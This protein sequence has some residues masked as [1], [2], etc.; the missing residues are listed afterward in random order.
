ML[1]SPPHNVAC[2]TWGTWPRRATIRTPAQEEEMVLQSPVPF[3]APNQ[4]LVSI[5]RCHTELAYQF[6]IHPK[7]TTTEEGDC[8]KSLAGSSRARTKGGV[9]WPFPSLAWVAGEIGVSSFF[10][11]FPPQPRFFIQYQIDFEYHPPQGIHYSLSLTRPIP[12][13]GIIPPRRSALRIR[14]RGAHSLPSVTPSTH[15]STLC[16]FPFHWGPFTYEGGHRFVLRIERRTNWSDRCRNPVQCALSLPEI[17]LLS[18]GIFCIIG[19]GVIAII[20]TYLLGCGL[21]SFAAARGS[22]PRIRI[23]RYLVSSFW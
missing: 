14:M 4:T 21:C 3:L 13:T 23:I 15:L 5:T 16:S 10:P 9:S 17:C 19:Y 2:C 20:V 1:P 12:G 11:R 18:A 22:I 7:S 8:P 6:A